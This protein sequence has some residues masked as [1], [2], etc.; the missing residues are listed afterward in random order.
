VT[1]KGRLHFKEVARGV[2][3]VLPSHL[4]TKGVYIYDLGFEISLWEGKQCFKGLR[5]VAAQR[6]PDVCLNNSY[7]I[8]P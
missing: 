7:L 2:G 8:C 1:K 4:S 3:Q 5:E 6:A